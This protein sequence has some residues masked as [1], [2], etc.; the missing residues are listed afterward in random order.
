M[1]LRIVDRD[2]TV[3]EVQARDEGSLMQVLRSFEWGVTAICGGACA[4]ATCHVYVAPE[5]ISRMP[6]QHSDE[7]DLIS[8]L[9]HGNEASRLSCQIHLAR[10][11]DGLCVT[12]APDE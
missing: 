6:P 4:C 5:W 3:R 1:L 9:A 8:D 7:R 11:L 12:L 2:G 10:E